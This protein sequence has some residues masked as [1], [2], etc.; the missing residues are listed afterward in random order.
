MIIIMNYQN[1]DIR[2]AVEAIFDIYGDKNQSSSLG[3][4]EI[5]AIIEEAL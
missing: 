4:K 2:R 1:A 5:E 3:Q